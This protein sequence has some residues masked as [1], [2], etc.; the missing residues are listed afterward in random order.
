MFCVSLVACIVTAAGGHATGASSAIGKLASDQETKITTVRDALKGDEQPSGLEHLG[1][2]MTL[3]GVLISDPLIVGEAASLVSFQDETGGLTLFT[4][5]TLQL[6]GHFKRGDLVEAQ[7]KLAQFKGMGEI[8][9]GTIRHLGT[10]PLPAPREALAVDLSGNRYKGQLVRMAGDLIVPGDFTNANR[11][12]VLRD[13]SGQI[14]VVISSK[15]FA[16][17]RFIDRLLQGGPVVITGIAGQSCENPPFHC[18]YRLIPRDPDDLSFAPVPPYQAISVS[19]A[20]VLLF[21]ALFYLLT[22]RRS[23]E[24]RAREM[25][26]LSESLRESESALRKSEERYRE[27]FENANDMVFTLDLEGNLVSL[28]KSGE[29]ITGYSREEAQNKSVTGCLKP[30]L[31]GRTRQML[32]GELA[33]EPRR[34]YETEIISKD[35]REVALEVSSRLIYENGK[36][37]AVQGI[38]R[39]ITNRRE[40]EEQLRQSQKMEAIGR[41]A[42]GV[43]HDFNNLLTV[44]KGHAEM[45]A[46]RIGPSHAARKDIQQIQQGADRAAS[47][48]QQLLAFSRQQVLKPRVLDLN[49]VVIE[50]AKMLPRLIGEDIELV[51]VPSALAAQVK[52][53]PGQLEQVILNL[54]VNARDAMPRGGQLTIELSNAQIDE[55]YVK[56]HA[57]VEAGRYVLL[58]VSDTGCGMDAETQKQIFDPFFTTKEL[59]KGTGLG[60]A[61]VYGVVKQSGGFVWVYSEVGK[62]STFKIYLPRVEQAL[63]G[64]SLVND[65]RPSWRGEET[66]LVVEDEDAV[67]ELTR[68]FLETRGYTVVEARNGAEAL[69]IAATHAHPIDLLVSDVIMPGMSGPE[70]AQQLFSLHPEIKVLYVSGYTAD[71]VPQGMLNTR[72]PFLSKPFSRDALLQNVREI[73]EGTQ[74]ATSE[75]RQPFAVA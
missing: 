14:T 35:G 30:E 59:G 68:E 52:A 24:R 64:L 61:T 20:L 15:F 71:A 72:A 53:D 46:D 60:L 9:L 34:E 6:S 16:N 70:L 38:A 28:N 41:L 45:L 22:R 13:R 51:M 69:Q 63:E 66:V 3:V 2:N 40:L 75:A 74:P 44:I 12:A 65:V 39:D 29:R 50:M 37:V 49:T 17:S 57:G 31:L 25:S 42:G 67:R 4:E 7:G 54:A 8:H 1:K 36:S 32:F 73:L 11:G 19:V 33:G 43:A 62:G 10:R 27:L 48:T 47:L 18:G 56:Q 26:K 5:D 23:A 21:G 58:A 55:H